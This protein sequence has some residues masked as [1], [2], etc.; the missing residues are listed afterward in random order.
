[1]EYV[2]STAAMRAADRATISDGITEET[3]IAR[4]GRAVLDAYPFRGPVAI[5]SG[6]GNNG[7]DGLA[8]ALC[9]KDAGIPC[10]VFLLDN[11]G[12]SGFSSFLRKAE[13][14]GV[15]LWHL[16]EETDFSPFAEIVDCLYGIGF[17][18]ALPGLVAS[19]V[20]KIN[21]ASAVVI[22]VD[23]PSGLSGDGGRGDLTVKADVTVAIQ[24]YK[25][26]HFLNRGRDVCGRLLRAD[27]GIGPREDAAF[28]LGDGDFADLLQPRKHDSHKGSYGY[29]TVM[30][31]CY[32]YAGAVKLANLS[33]SAL[34]T[35]CGVARLAVPASLREAVA[36]YLLESTLCLLP[37]EDGKMIFDEEAL[38]NAV[39]GSAAVALG[40]GWGRSPAYE[41][42]L[43]FLLQHLTAPLLIDADGLNTL[44]EMGTDILKTAKCPVILTPHPKEFQRLSGLSTNEILSDPVSR[45]KEFAAAYGCILLLKGPTTVVTDGKATYL[46][47]KGCGGMATAGSGDVLSGVLAG[48]LGYNDPSPHAVACGAYVAGLA[49]EMAEVDENPISMTA[50]DTARHVGK[51]VSKLLKALE[52]PIL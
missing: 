44:A 3:L 32:E 26:G 33:A 9:L 20:Q 27:I 42:I 7:A 25:Y 52:K 45:A 28:L 36:P 37:D 12:S 4:A 29:V 38:T 30:G 22:S 51:A 14:A 47:S 21:D 46:V 10:H 41:K 8:L 39:R 40:M 35:G 50:G 24:W 2:L 15:P 1:M 23:I 17:H 18:G 34:R 48:L 5:L 6:P 13:A 43:A 16:S 19:A 11:S 31:G 49:G